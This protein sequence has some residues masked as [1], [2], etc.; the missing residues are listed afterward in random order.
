MGQFGRR[1][2]RP[3]SKLAPLPDLALDGS[4]QDCSLRKT[5]ENVK[6]AAST[7]SL[8]EVT[9]RR[10]A[11]GVSLGGN[12]LSVG[13]T[14]LVAAATNAIIV[15]MLPPHYLPVNLLMVACLTWLAWADHRRNPN[16]LYFYTSL[17]AVTL[18]TAVGSVAAE[19]SDG[20]IYTFLGLCLIVGF[21]A[22]SARK[23]GLDEA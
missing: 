10:V 9:Q 12:A 17:I 16:K 1:T 20:M 2:S 11:S 23:R 13:N 18:A 22:E 14:Y 21:A 6:Q 4:Q 3:R 15:P 7:G 8:L 19:R 5:R